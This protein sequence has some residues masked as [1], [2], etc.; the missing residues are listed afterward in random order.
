VLAFAQGTPLLL[1][2]VLSMVNAIVGLRMTNVSYL[3]FW[4]IDGVLKIVI[5]AWM[6]FTG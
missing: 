4:V 6:L 3:K 1:L 2:G 5:G